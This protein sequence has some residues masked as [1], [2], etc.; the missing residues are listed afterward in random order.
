MPLVNAGRK[1]KVVGRLELN[2]VGV[3]ALTP[4][5]LGP[6]WADDAAARAAAET[7]SHSG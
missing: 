5:S 6:E 3:Q 7:V 2:A 1:G 4:A